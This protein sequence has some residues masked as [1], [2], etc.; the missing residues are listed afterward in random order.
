MIYQHCLFITS[1]FC[2]VI[3]GAY[4]KLNILVI[5]CQYNKEVEK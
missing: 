3:I 1:F 4:F 2:V 5:L